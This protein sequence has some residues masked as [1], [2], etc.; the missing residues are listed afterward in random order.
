MK[1]TPIM[2]KEDTR[3]LILQLKLDL[4]LKSSDLVIR[5]LIESFN[6]KKEE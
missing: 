1:H 6:V 4:K 5:K 3:N 2:V